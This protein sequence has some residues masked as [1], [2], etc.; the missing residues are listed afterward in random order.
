MTNMSD[1]VEDGR[2]DMLPL[3]VCNGKENSHFPIFHESEKG[4]D[5]VQ[6]WE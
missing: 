3:E 6:D 5:V 1:G 2:N 4:H